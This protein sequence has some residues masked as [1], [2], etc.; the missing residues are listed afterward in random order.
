MPRAPRI[1]M[2]ERAAMCREAA[3]EFRKDAQRALEVAKQ[4]EA[5]ADDLDRGDVAGLTKR[6]PLP[7]KE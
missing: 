6:H 4:L 5:R 3:A 2:Q 1:T 7:P